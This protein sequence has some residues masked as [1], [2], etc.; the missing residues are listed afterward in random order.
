MRW[1]LPL[2]AAGVLGAVGL[3]L[4]AMV[5]VRRLVASL[6]AVTSGLAI[7]LNL[8]LVVAAAFWALS[9]HGNELQLA[10]RAKRSDAIISED[11][12]L[13]DATGHSAA[14]KLWLHGP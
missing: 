9:V 11:P 6:N 1:L 2:I 13:I 14:G 3:V 8:A 5:V 10:R 4:A 7:A 12:R